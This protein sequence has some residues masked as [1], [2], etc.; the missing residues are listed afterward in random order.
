MFIPQMLIPRLYA[1]CLIPLIFFLY[2]LSLIPNPSN[3]Y[4]LSLSLDRYTRTMNP[5]DSE[6][7]RAFKMDPMFHKMS[8]IFDEAGSK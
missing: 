3:V 7:E 1:L 2:P 6:T 8:K 5:V 4:P